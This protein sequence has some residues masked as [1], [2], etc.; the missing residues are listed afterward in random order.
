MPISTSTPGLR[1]LGLTEIPIQREIWPRQRIVIWI[2]TH[3]TESLDA[4]TNTSIFNI[5]T[6]PGLVQVYM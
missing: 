6:I 3:A 4:T 1:Y 5:Y 2:G